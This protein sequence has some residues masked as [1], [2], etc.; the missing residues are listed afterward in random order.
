MLEWQKSMTKHFM[1]ILRKSKQICQYYTHIMRNKD[2]LGVA[3][4][5]GQC[6][7]FVILRW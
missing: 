2:F 4:S 5:L 6:L 1:K 3:G 7:R